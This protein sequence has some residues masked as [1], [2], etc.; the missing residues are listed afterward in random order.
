MTA[1]VVVI[2]VVVKLP[3][4]CRLGVVEYGFRPLSLGSGRVWRVPTEA[5]DSVFALGLVYDKK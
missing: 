4:T 5:V 2:V 1:A 3:M